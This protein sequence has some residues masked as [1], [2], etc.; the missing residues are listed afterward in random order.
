MLQNVSQQWGNLSAFLCVSYP[1]DDNIS[2]F[3]PG[4]MSADNL[5]SSRNS[6]PTIS[7]CLYMSTSS[8]E[9]MQVVA[10]FLYTKF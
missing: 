1:W 3:Q 4:Q 9:L 2:G 5:S 7:M 10:K 8:L 6:E